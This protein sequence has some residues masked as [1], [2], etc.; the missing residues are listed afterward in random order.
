MS[1]LKLKETDLKNLK[2]NMK[3]LKNKIT[4]LRKPQQ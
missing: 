4:K 2:I 3:N 1:K